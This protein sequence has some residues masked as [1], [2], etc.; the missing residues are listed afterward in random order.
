MIRS[1]QQYVEKVFDVR[2][3]WFPDARL[4]ELWFR[5]LN[6]SK[7]QLLP[8]A[9]WRKSC[10]ELS[11]V[12]SF[13]N[14][15]P[16]Y[17]SREPIDDWEWYYLMQHY[18]LPTRLLDWTESPLVALY[19]ALTTAD[20]HSIPCVWVMDPAK[21]NRVSQGLTEELILVP[22]S[23][24]SD[25]D[26]KYWLPG[27]CGRDAK[28]HIFQAGSRFRDNSKPLAVFPK[29]YNPRIVAQRGVFTIHGKDEIS[30]E[31]ILREAVDEDDRRI[32]QILID[33][34]DV[35]TL[36]D[37]LW[38]LGFSKSSLFPEPQSFAEDLK[39]LYSVK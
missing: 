15:V 35:D 12:L 37:D 23:T 19:F 36:L 39:R 22:L 25:S 6:D 33:P 2:Q 28:L 16:S 5:G 1:I 24:G 20:Q 7:L 4:S 34:R 8:G 32:A 10:D 14:M 30:I 38:A 13:Q 9:Y 26:T 18:G 27:S 21:L 29:R 3:V 11:L 17:L 31:R